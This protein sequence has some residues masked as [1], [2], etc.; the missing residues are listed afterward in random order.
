MPHLPQK[1]PKKLLT[2]RTSGYT[3]MSANYS[4]VVF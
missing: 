1:D 3:F 2:Q 4:R